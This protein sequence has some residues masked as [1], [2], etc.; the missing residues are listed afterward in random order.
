MKRAKRYLIVLFVAVTLFASQVACGET[1][2]EAVR[3]SGCYDWAAYNAC[4]ENDTHCRIKACQNP[5]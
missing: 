3:A 5:N 1:T 2:R 4:A